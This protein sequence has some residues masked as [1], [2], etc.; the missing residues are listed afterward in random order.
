MKKAIFF[1]LALFA[2]AIFSIQAIAA[3]VKAGCGRPG[4]LH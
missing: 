2:A 1:P 4:L 3:E